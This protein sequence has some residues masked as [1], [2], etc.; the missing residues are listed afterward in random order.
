[1][2]SIF[3]QKKIFFYFFVIFPGITP[4][5]NAEN[6][7]DILAGM[8]PGQSKTVYAPAE[9]KIFCHIR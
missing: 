9:G 2:S 4:G 6:R 7:F 3:L 8:P 1:L 5:A